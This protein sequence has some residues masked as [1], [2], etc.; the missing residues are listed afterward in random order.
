MQKIKLKMEKDVTIRQAYEEFIR[1]CKVK[2][3]SPYTLKYY[4]NNINVFGL[5]CDLDSPITIID[6]D[7][8]NQYVLHL[9]EQNIKDYT[10]S[11]YMKAIR[12]VLYFFMQKDY[13]EDFKV[14]IP[15]AD[16]ELK[17][18]YTDT[19]LKILLKKPNLKKS[20]F[21]EYRTWVMI[22]Y[23]IATG[24]RLKNLQYLKAKDLDFENKV[25]KLS[26]TKNRKQTLLPL[27]NSIIE[28][29]SEYLK[30]RKGKPDDYV[31]CKITGEQLGKTG[32][33]QAIVHY[34]HKR[35]V[36]KTSV[37]LY[38]HTYAKKYLLN[39]GDL[40]RLQRLLCHADISTTKDYLNLIIDDLQLDYDS[41]NP[42]E[43]MTKYNKRLNIAK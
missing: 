3:Y 31:F 6:E 10:V 32:I 1:R 4:E 5:F 19:E 2:N 27:S 35:G 23:L 34:S 7:L 26:H 33:E 9:Q 20:S 12:A 30:Y 42:H 17:E 22:N 25:V 37:H 43:Q 11:S 36:D 39:G 41:L 29:L 24:Q 38:R 8:I 18:I 16:R 28:V 40:A 14:T 15:K 13:I 21:V